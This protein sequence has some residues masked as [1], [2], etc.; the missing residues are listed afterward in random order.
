MTYCIIY[1]D[2]VIVFGHSEKEH[3]EHLCIMFEHF[4]EFNL[5]LKPSK[6][7]FFQLEIVYLAHHVSCEG[8]HPSRENVCAIEEFP[9][10]ETFTQVCAFC[11]LVGH[12]GH[13]IQG[14][15]HI[16]RPCKWLNARFLILLCL[17]CALVWGN[18]RERL[19]IEIFVRVLRSSEVI[20][21][22]L[23]K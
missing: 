21:L 9:M 17:K 5:K 4:R 6:C 19:R 10:A 2:D 13:F 7:P 22:I 8:I 16:T 11:G 14:F 3:L 23:C 1:L 15:A 20:S 18:C 12:Y